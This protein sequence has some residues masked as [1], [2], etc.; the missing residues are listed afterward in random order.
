MSSVSKSFRRKSARIA[1]RENKRLSVDESA[2]TSSEIAED[3]SLDKRI[4]VDENFQTSPEVHRDLF[5]EPIPKKPKITPASENNS[6]RNTPVSK[7]KE[8]T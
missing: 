7:K 8:R 6:R 3:F 1:T 5:G 2:C 4:D